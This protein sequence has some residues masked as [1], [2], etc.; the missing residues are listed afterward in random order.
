MMKAA[1]VLSRDSGTR[2]CGTFDRAASERNRFSCQICSFG[3]T[4]K[5][6]KELQHEKIKCRWK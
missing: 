4:E 6:M 5:N 2:S 3:W 1:S